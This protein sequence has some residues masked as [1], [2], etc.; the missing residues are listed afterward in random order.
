[1]VLKE[2]ASAE[3][4]LDEVR[5]FTRRLKEGL[6]RQARA[7]AARATHRVSSSTGRTDS[8]RR[9]RHADGLRAFGHA[10][11]RKA[12]DVLV[13]DTGAAAL[14]A[15]NEHPDVDAVLMDIMMPEMDGF[16]AI[17]R[18]RTDSRFAKLLVVALTAKAM[19]GDR[20]KCL[21]AGATEYLPKPVDGDRLLALLATHLGTAAR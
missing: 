14:A 13:A 3:R 16:E 21:E 17:R 1:M 8:D 15:L 11:G 5:L 7:D 12:L 6:R 2:G 10:C 18:I 9:R 20:E 19:K 4:L